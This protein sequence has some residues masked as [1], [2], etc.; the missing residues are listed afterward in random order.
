MTTTNHP[1]Q[2][3]RGEDVC[4]ISNELRLKD[5]K[6]LLD[7]FTQIRT[8]HSGNKNVTQALF[9]DAWHALNRMLT[10]ARQSFNC[11]AVWPLREVS[12]AVHDY[13]QACPKQKDMTEEHW[14]QIDKLVSH[15]QPPSGNVLP[16][17]PEG[18]IL[19]D[20]IRTSYGYD[21]HL[22]K[23]NLISS[24]GFHLKTGQGQ[25]PRAAVE[26]ALDAI[27]GEK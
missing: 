5:G 7:F 21:C 17:L 27:E 14:E 3:S 16:E 10:L 13:A 18:W 1:S 19:R 26:A 8:E 15:A 25:T 11:D 22:T 9:N 6:L 4:E 23:P 24:A 20:I 2:S 12:V